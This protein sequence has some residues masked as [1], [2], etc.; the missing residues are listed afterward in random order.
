M[1]VVKKKRRKKK[2]YPTRL[3]AGGK[4]SGSGWTKPPREKSRDKPDKSDGGRRTESAARRGEKLGAA[5]LFQT[6]IYGGTRLT[7]VKN[8]NRDKGREHENRGI[9][10]RGRLESIGLVRLAS[11][12]TFV[13]HS[14]NPGPSSCSWLNQ[15]TDRPK[16]RLVS[17]VACNRAHT[18]RG[19]KLGDYCTV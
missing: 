4:A 8:R 5:C 14:Q 16:Q 15:W 7:N 11:R 10:T 18:G 3:R 2:I 6:V 17:I 13:D 19:E 9:A 12:T 1:S